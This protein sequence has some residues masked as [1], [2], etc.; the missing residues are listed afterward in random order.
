MQENFVCYCE[1]KQHFHV[2]ILNNKDMMMLMLML[3][4][5]KK[6]NQYEQ[7]ST[8]QAQCKWN[9]WEK[10][11]WLLFY[12][13]KT[14]KFSHSLNERIS[15]IEKNK[16]KNWNNRKTIFR[17]C[18]IFHITLFYAVIL[19]MNSVAA[20]THFPTIKKCIRF[21]CAQCTRFIIHN[22]FNA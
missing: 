20:F 4:T 12:I 14:A 11:L 3:M 22:I 21:E 19:W 2:E 1:V 17:F 5:M 7:H 18:A 13:R 15:T 8:E 6:K 9:G 10:A 16:K